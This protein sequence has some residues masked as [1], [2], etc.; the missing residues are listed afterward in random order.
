M[1]SRREGTVAFLG[2]V[3]ILAQD[4]H[5]Q[6]TL[7][8]WWHG[9]WHRWRE[10]WRHAISK[11]RWSAHAGRAHVGYCLSFCGITAGDAVYDGLSLLMTDLL[12]IVDD[13]AEVIAADR[14]SVV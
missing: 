9:S 8:T 4:G 13:V 14:K 7:L 6:A 10:A 11:G 3:S 1:G 5:H 12:I 2:M